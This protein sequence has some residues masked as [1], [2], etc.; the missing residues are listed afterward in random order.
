MKA[1]IAIALVGCCVFGGILAL[2][3][4]EESTPKPSEFYVLRK[5][6]KDLEARVAVLERLLKTTPREPN[7]LILPPSLHGRRVPESWSRREFNGMPYY[8]IPLQHD[9]NQT[10]SPR[11]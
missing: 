5:Q 6:V 10:P 11:K 7:A 3:A 4:E 8:V 2:A 1:R 9:P